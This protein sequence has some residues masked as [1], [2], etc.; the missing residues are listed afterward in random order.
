LRDRCI[1]RMVPKFE[2]SIK[3]TRCLARGVTP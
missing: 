3:T 2:E 1:W